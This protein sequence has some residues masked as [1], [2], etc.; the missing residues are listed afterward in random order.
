MTM[1]IRE[2]RP[3][4]GTEALFHNG[5][6]TAERRRQ[7]HG[8]ALLRYCVAWLAPEKD[9]GF[10]ALTNVGGEAGA[11]ACDKAAAAM[12]RSEG[13]AGSGQ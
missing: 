12:L 3:W 5:S 1:R 13:L 4:A 2:Q 7:E 9:R 8:A 10:L 11:K 6:N